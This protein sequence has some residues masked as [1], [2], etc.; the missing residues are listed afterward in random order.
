MDARLPKGH[1]SVD[2]SFDVASLA[3]E[4]GRTEGQLM[5]DFSMD[6]IEGMLA[7][8]RLQSLIGL[9]G[10]IAASNE[11]AYDSWVD[12]G[13]KGTPPVKKYG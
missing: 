8:Q 6:E 1:I 2:P 3:L 5:C 4:L 7:A 9:A 11:S 13:R 12:G 10:N